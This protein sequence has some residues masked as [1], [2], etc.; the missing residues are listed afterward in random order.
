MSPTL[1]GRLSVRDPRFVGDLRNG[2][3]PGARVSNNV[4]HFMNIY[5]NKGEN[6]SC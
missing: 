5:G 1:F 6:T 3:K 4:E 2:R